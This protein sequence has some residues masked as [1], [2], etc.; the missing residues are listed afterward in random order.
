MN[1]ILIEPVRRT[2]ASRNVLKRVGRAT[3]DD[4]GLDRIRFLSSRLELFVWLCSGI[5]CAFELHT[6]INTSDEW[7][8]LWTSA[9]GASVHRATV[10]GSTR[11]M[12]P[13]RAEPQAIC[14]LHAEFAERSRLVDKPVRRT[15]LIQLSRAARSALQ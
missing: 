9:A 12:V 15:V 7:S 8:L 3:V 14:E 5:T 2:R 13:L 10:A 4:S 1:S 11:L 6:A